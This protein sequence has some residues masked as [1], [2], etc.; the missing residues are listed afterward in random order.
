MSV[1]SGKPKP[2]LVPYLVVSSTTYTIGTDL[3][4]LKP[5]IG[6]NATWTLPA[7]S[8]LQKGA[9]LWI[10]NQNGFTI[11]LVP[12]GTDTINGAASYIVSSGSFGTFYTGS[13]WNAGAYVIPPSGTSTNTN[14]GTQSLASVTVGTNDT[15]FGYQALEFN[16]T[17]SSNTGIGYQALNTN[18]SG[19]SNT[20]LGKSSLPSVTTGS[21]NIGIG[22]NSGNNLTIGSGNIYIG[23]SA[24]SASETNVIRLGDP[25]MQTETYIAGG[26]SITNETVSA[27]AANVLSAANIVGGISSNGAN[28]TLDTGANLDAAIPS[29]STTVFGQV[30]KCLVVNTSGANI[31]ITGAA[32]TTLFDAGAVVPLHSSRTLSFRRTAAGTYTVY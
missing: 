19:A 18:V 31:T 12:S 26:Y 29:L 21:N 28:F 13:Q 32:G 1:V 24:S 25:S 7:L 11:T 27:M 22:L 10:D 14:M 30:I 8:S 15:A 17:G 5:F 6:A 20:A 3:G 16:T 23:S 4:I 9:F 2:L